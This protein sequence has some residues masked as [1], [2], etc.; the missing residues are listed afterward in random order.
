MNNLP[1]IILAFILFLCA[2]VLG[3]HTAREW[4]SYHIICPSEEQGEALVQSMS[5]GMEVLCIYSKDPMK[6]G[7]SSYKSGKLSPLQ[8]SLS[9]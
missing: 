9:N 2:L 8:S 3:I 6:R 5:D 7:R 4:N 1:Q